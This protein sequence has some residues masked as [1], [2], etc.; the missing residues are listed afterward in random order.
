MFLVFQTGGDVF[1]AIHTFAVV[2]GQVPRKEWRAQVGKPQDGDTV[3]G[4]LCQG[5]SC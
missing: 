5:L 2:P 4:M 3:V 1:T